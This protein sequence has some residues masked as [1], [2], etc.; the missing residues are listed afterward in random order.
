MDQQE[1]RA[2]EARCI[3]EEPPGCRAGCPLGVDGRAFARTVAEGEMAA[4]RAILEK[5]MPLTGIVARLCEAPCEQYCLR[6]A[7]GGAVALGELERACVAAAP[8]QGKILRLPPRPKK[9]VVVGGGPSSLSL[10]F[11]LGK[12]GYPVTLFHSGEH[13]GGWLNRLPEQVLPAAVLEEELA[14]L[15]DLGVSFLPMSQLSPQLYQEAEG[16]YLGQDDALPG[17]ITS[18]LR[19]PDHLTFALPQ[20]GWFSGGTSDEDDRFRFISDISQ[21]R[22]AAISLDRFLQGASLTASRVAL[23]HGRTELFTRTDQV[24]PRQRIL[25]ADPRG[26][27]RGEALQEASRCLDCQCLECVRHCQYLQAFG[28]YPKVYA[29]RI[30]NNSAIVRGNHQANTLINSCSLCRQ[31]ETLCPND[32]S[33]ADLCLEARQTMVREERMPPSAHWFALEEMRSA[34]SEG[35]LRRHAPGTTNSRALFF[36][37]CQLAGTRP[38]QTLA[39]YER[40]REL[41][42]E[43]GIWL[44]CCA[45]PAHWAG[46]TTE[47]AAILE[48][49]ETG[50]S[51]MGRPR[52]ITACSSCL[53]IFRQHLPTVPVESAWVV[54][55]AHPQAATGTPRPA[56]A[57]SDPCTSRDDPQT[58]AAVR[59]ILARLDQALAP[60]AM[61]GEQTECCGFGGLMES[62]NPKLARQ[63]AAARVAQTEAEILTYCAM[64]RD[65]LARAGRPVSYLL[66]LLLPEQALP[67]ATAPVTI[68]ARR[69]QR[70]QL[71]AELLARYA[72]QEGPAPAPWEALKLNISEPVAVMMEERRILE[73]DLRQ[74]LYLADQKRL[75][76]SIDPTDPAKTRGS[77][78]IHPESGARIAS[79][80]LG[81]VTF[82]V[83]YQQ[84][85]GVYRIERC[86]SHR[87][88][89]QG[90]RP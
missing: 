62:A 78:F 57:L 75:K 36:P 37:G 85:A 70:R 31:C 54:L 73:D 35:A 28:A 5:S 38:E 33:M 69:S 61:S 21:G 42:P 55:A 81:Q 7:L 39:L 1:L 87:M 27:S 12:K 43:T 32:F 29:R 53:Q 4:A 86:W 15:Q 56:L 79:A 83:E 74:L 80:R 52:L 40:L 2:W 68:S 8:S 71:K 88:V 65:Q 51:E 34:R 24:T 25:P 59:T 50:W 6:Q 66:D 11:D 89:I 20:T 48:Q 26:Y 13:P 3:Q 9:V 84:E 30:Y 23:R 14:R 18:L 82:W 63:V 49:L 77:C 60:L 46:S 19:Q 72:P 47:F 22:E 41:E 58:Q 76:E 44:D 45:A 17:A 10:A 16:C 67:A 90:G 64:C